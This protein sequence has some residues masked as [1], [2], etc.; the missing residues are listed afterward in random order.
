MQKATSTPATVAQ[1]PVNEAL[2]LLRHRFK[3]GSEVAIPCLINHPK[4]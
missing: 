4:V 2:A 1:A 3:T